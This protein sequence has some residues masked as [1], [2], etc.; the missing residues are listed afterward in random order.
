[1]HFAGVDEEAWSTRNAEFAAV[2]TAKVTVPFASDPL[3]TQPV[4]TVAETTGEVNPAPFAS[5]TK[6]PK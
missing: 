2:F 3:T 6:Y 1:V 5:L 4:V